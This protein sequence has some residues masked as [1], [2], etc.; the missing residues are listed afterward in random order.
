MKRK[1]YKTTKNSTGERLTP[2]EETEQRLKTAEDLCVEDEIEERLV[3]S[4][5]TSLEA[6]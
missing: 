5:L 4:E 2:E 6:R 3:I 1:T